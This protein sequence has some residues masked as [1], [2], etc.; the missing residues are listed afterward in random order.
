MPGGTIKDCLET[1]SAPLT[2]LTSCGNLGE[3]W[4]F[5]KKAYF[6][7]ILLVHPDKGGDA[8]VFRDVQAAF[9][10]LRKL[11][12]EAAIESFS[13][14]LEQSTASEYKGAKDD[15]KGTSTPSWEYY[16]EAAKEVT[17]TY[18][19]ELA[20]SNRS[21]CQKSGNLME[22]G[23]IRI[24]FMMESGT[25]GLWVSLDFWRVPSK[26]WLGLPDPAKC[27]DS[28]KF[29][30]ALKRMNEVSLSGI[31][32]LVPADRKKVVRY[33]MD[34]QHWTFGGLK[35]KIRKRGTRTQA[36]NEDEDG[37]VK[38]SSTES[39][40]PQNADP[41]LSLV[42]AKKERAKF[43]I[44]V[45]KSN[46]KQLLKGKTFVITGVFPEIGG[47]EGLQLGKERTK[48]MITSFGGKVTS[49]V[50]GKTDVLVVGK[51]PG[52]NKVTQA[53]KNST[54]LLSL[55]DMKVG[56][57][58]GSLEDINTSR[59]MMIDDFSKGYSQRR[60]GPNGRALRASKK[61][62][63]IASG[64]MPP[65]LADKARMQR[66]KLARELKA[67]LPLKAPTAKKRPASALGKSS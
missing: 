64:R 42:V 62:L 37:P 8:A 46:D 9:E 10:A 15:F 39:S 33:V 67:V 13:S 43:V 1:I 5:I 34:K 21:R 44:P 66:K 22:K 40:G 55:H 28:R 52:F 23:T 53:R 19:V 58:Q 14:S 17:A 32:E 63:A 29:E 47:G 31:R 16:A 6:K 57:E 18:R 65:A 50:S 2:G 45:P 59:P 61:E 11:F 7:K 4:S 54:R 48:K 3:E 36:P 26:I 38:E 56:L 25:Y 41:N 30:R 51:E 20:R 49:S 12:D 24:G 27:R 60:G 35:E